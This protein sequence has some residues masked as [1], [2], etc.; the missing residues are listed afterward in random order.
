MM[1]SPILAC[2]RAAQLLVAVPAIILVQRP[3]MALRLDLADRL[4]HWWLGI[5]RRILGI[6]AVVHGRDIVE[7]PALFVTNHISYL[8]ISVLGSVINASFVARADLRDWPVFGYLS[9][10]QRTEFV[11]RRP[12]FAFQQMDAIRAR[13]SA[14]DRLILFPEGTSSD[15]NNVL[16]FKSTLFGVAEA[17]FAAAK[18]PVQPIS[19]AYTRLDGFPLGRLLRPLFAWYGDM[20]FAA[21]LWR[22]MGFGRLQVDIVVH[23]PVTSDQ[24]GSRKAL[25]RHCEAVVTRGFSDL[26]A[27]RL[28]VTAA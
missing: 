11:D 10:L 9:T 15:G 27:G 4:P 22:H 20:T 7:G 17:E 8:D 23:E 5:C 26:M 2:L 19:I 3:A 24:F 12:R 1:R 13:L 6:D 28:P 14:G 25:A 18:V 16:P 21:H